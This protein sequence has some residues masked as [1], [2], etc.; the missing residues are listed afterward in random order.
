MPSDLKPLGVQRPADGEEKRNLGATKADDAEIP[1]QL[2]YDR[3][4]SPHSSI[5]LEQKTT[6]LN[7]VRTFALWWWQRRIMKEFLTWFKSK[8]PIFSQRLEVREILWYKRAWKDWQAGQ[9][10]IRRCANSSWWEWDLGSR[11]LHWRWHQDYQLIIHDGVQPWF[12][13]KPP[14][15]TLS[16]RG[17]PDPNLCDCIKGKLR[18]VREKGYIILGTVKSLTSF[19]TVPKGDDD[20]RIV[21]NGTQS[22]LNESI[23]APWFTLP[24]I[25]RHLRTMMPGTFMGDLDIGEQFL[26]F[27]LHTKVQPYAWVDFAAYFPEEVVNHSN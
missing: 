4:L 25:E 11:P 24:T 21:Y 1:F 20:I 22:G 17:E 13:S 10:C 6:P 16:Q 14:K 7:N 27:I 18:K 3:I 9:D 2:W 15:Y 8:Y 5:T 23:W 26:N 19:F 12:L